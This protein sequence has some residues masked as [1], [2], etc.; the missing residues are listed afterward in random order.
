MRG[1]RPMTLKADFQRF[2]T[3]VLS[4]K[5]GLRGKLIATKVAF[6]RPSGNVQSVSPSPQ[7]SWFQ[8]TLLPGL[9]F[10]AVVIGGGYATG[11]ELATFF[12]PAGPRGGLYGMLLAMS[13][14]SVICTVTFLFALA[15]E[16]RDYRTFF[17]KLLGPFW[18]AFEIAYVLA[19]VLILAVF[20]A[21]AGAIFQAIFGWPPIAGA[22]ALIVLIA[23]FAGL[24]N[25][26]VEQLFKYVS[27]LLYVTYALFLALS[28][29]RFGDRIVSAFSAPSPTTGWVAGGLTYTGY[30][31]IGAVVI[32][33]IVRHLKTRR[34]AVV[35]GMLAGPLAMLPA[36]LFFLSMAAFYPQIKDQVLPSDFILERLHMPVFRYLFQLMIF[37]ALLESGTGQVHAINERVAQAYAVRTRKAFTLKAR[38]LLTSALLIGSVF[39]ADRLGLVALI[40]NG[41]RFL[42]Y[43]FLIVFV[44]PL[45]TVGLW[46]IIR[47]P[48]PLL[49]R[50]AV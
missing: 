48:G 15:T 49:P 31:I 5:F 37:A 50:P 20:A 29:S 11:R 46:R 18:P 12:L 34:Q 47:S 38:L 24:G 16:S 28:L 33:P 7:S 43:L 6:S 39:V 32:L 26:A 27:I 13:L 22:L 45:M 17:H 25:E 30:N 14:W 1:H 41:Y 44:L 9:A 36:I 19:M 4:G 2:T 23:L 3:R 40:A 21:A 8:R 10:K 35:A 42:A